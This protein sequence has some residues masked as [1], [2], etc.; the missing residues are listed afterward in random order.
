M[1]ITYD[2]VK[3]QAN[4]A[5]HGVDMALA[6]GLEWDTLIAIDDTRREYGEPRMIGYALMGDRLFNVIFVDRGNA[7]RIISLRKANPREVKFYGTHSN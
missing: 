5:K 2:E 1:Q 6:N 4:I 7:R 3:N